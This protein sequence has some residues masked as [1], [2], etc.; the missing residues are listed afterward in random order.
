VALT[1]RWPGIIIDNGAP[2]ININNTYD[3]TNHIKGKVIKDRFDKLFS[4]H[5]M[6]RLLLIHFFAFKVVFKLFYFHIF[7]HPYV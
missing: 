2:F 1:D 7:P 5:Y 6:F 4:V 3:V